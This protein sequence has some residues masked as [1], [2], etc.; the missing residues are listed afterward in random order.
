MSKAALFITAQKWKELKSPS[1]D[2]G[3][4]EVCSVHTTEYYSSIKRYK[5]LQGGWT[6][7]ALY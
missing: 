7:E 5:H 6:L 2:K 1:N 3:R 4:N